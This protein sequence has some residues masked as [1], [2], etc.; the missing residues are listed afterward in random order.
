MSITDNWKQD[1]TKEIEELH[2]F[3]QNWFNGTIP[4]SEFTR[5]TEVMNASF[6]MISP[7]GE[8]II[9]SVLVGSLEKSYG[10]NSSIR[11]SVAKTVVHEIS[12]D[13][14][15][16]TYNEIQHQGDNTTTRI[17]SALFQRNEKL[18]NNYM[19]LHVHETWK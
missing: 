18:T 15:L 16:A 9:R 10:K 4:Q 13:F 6:Q 12:P 14:Y 2:E 17:S 19:W 3:F 8:L 1:I 11:I 5:F 7:Q